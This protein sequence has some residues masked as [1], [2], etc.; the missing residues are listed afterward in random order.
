[1][2]ELGIGK[3]NSCQS[4]RFLFIHEF[5]WAFEM[6]GSMAIIYNASSNMSFHGEFIGCMVFKL[7]EFSEMHLIIT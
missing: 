2:E 3:G 7:T 5:S 6:M 4:S 1:M